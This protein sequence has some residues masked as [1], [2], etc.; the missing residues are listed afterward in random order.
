[1]HIHLCTTA[2]QTPQ[3]LNWYSH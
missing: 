3:Q 2:Q 1:M